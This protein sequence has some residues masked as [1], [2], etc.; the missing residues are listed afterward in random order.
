MSL[1][2]YAQASLKPFKE[3]GDLNEL[4]VGE[5]LSFDGISLYPFICCVLRGPFL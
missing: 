1:V 5:L 3:P 4:A 2:E